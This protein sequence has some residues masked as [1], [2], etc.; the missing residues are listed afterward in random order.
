M[1][2]I[3]ILNT[4]G[5]LSSVVK[6]QGMAPGISTKDML[7]EIRMV[8]RNTELAMKDISSLD[9][10]NISPNNWAAMASEVALAKEEFD[11]V[12]IIHG[13]D[14]M[15]YTSSMLSFMLQNISIPV[16][17]TGSQ[18]SISDPVAD[19]MENLRCAIYMA[20]S[21]YA[22]VFLAF[23]RKVI[24][25]C[26]ASK[27]NTVSFD[28]FKSINYP[29]IAEISSAGMQV[30]TDMIPQRKGIF[31]LN[32]KYSDRIAVAKL[33]PGI[34]RDYFTSLIGSGVRGVYIEAYGL[35]GMPFLGTDLTQSVREMTD[36]GIFVL[37]GTQ[38]IYGGSNL[39]V[40]ETGRKA[41]EAGA[42]EAYDMTSE[43]AVTKLMWVLGQTDDPKSVREYFTIDLCNEVTIK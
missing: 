11:G 23:N 17:I 5:T 40:Y 26:R 39:R 16:V 43:S 24:L 30:R 19:A 14:T 22:G 33:F 8:S 15:A 28:A 25:G 21:G 13:T 34:G 9:S 29:N 32:T 20:A 1:K 41:L 12:V 27:I 36:S 38:C 2:R 35:G 6:Q 7:D 10:A 18:L 37:V 3:L 42:H 4:G 31:S